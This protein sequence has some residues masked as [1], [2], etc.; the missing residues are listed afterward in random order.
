[1]SDQAEKFFLKSKT[2]WGV[3]VMA[4]P[5]LLPV[6]GVTLGAT[7]TALITETGD[8]VMTAIGALIAVYGRF[9]AGG[10]RV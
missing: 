7:E 2:I 5:A 8:K 9:K 6:F 4:M 3:V 10:V 1:M